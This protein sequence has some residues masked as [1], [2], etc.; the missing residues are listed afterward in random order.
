MQFLKFEVG[1]VI[2]L[3]KAHPC[4]NK[5]FKILRVG[6]EMR[7][8]CLG[9]EHDMIIDRIKL[10]KATKKITTGIHKKKKRI[11][12]GYQAR[13]MSFLSRLFPKCA[14]SLITNTFKLSKFE[15]FDDIF[16]K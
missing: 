5:Q 9:C 15:L 13:A 2:E 4:G 16:D 14:P 8:V 12:F 10:E 3:K 1:D 7:I 11:V 6:G